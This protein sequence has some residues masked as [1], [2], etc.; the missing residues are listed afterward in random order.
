VRRVLVLCVTVLVAVIGCGELPSAAGAAPL[1]VP[2][3][4]PAPASDRVGRVLVL[5]LPSVTW[6]DL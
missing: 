3:T 6:A 5:S 4:P 2:G 1:E